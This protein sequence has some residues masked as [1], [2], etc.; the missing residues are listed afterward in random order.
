MAAIAGTV[1]GAAGVGAQIYG[2]SRAG[3]AA[4]DAQRAQNALNQQRIELGR[5]QLD[6]ARGNYDQWRQEFQP[7]LDELMSESMRD[8]TPDYG[9]ISADTNAAFGAARRD[10]EVGLERRGVDPSDGAFGAGRRRF[11]IGQA[12]AEV[13]ARNTARRGA[14]DDKFRRLAST[15][16]FGTGLMQSGM[17]AVSGGF[18]AVQNAMGGASG[19]YGA[20]A[21]AHAGN[22]AAGWSGAFRGLNNLI[23]TAMQPTDG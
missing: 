4:D 6:W 13:N 16:G 12:L 11:G 14:E 15:Y 5:E 1:I 8:R 2:A 21:G 23:D 22:A 18:S 10:Y 9:A 20:Q 17:N 3:D 19:D 7:V